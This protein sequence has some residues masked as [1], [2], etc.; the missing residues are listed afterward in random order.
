MTE[1]DAGQWQ[2]LAS[3][4]TDGT[5]VLVAVRA[6]EQGPAEVDVVRWT[7]AQGSG[8][9]CW[10]ATDSD[11]DCRVVYADAELSGWMPLPTPLPRLRSAGVA[12]GRAD[13]AKTN[14]GLEMDG[15]AI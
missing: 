1:P 10:I 11:P 3:A 4:P 12:S 9:E 14:D 13:P 7:K 8:E 2:P 6:S 15:S 5:R